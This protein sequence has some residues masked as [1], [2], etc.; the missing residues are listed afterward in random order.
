M[1]GDDGGDGTFDD[2][3]GSDFFEDDAGP[4]FSDDDAGSAP[5]DDD[6]GRK[7]RVGNDGFENVMISN[8]S[9]E[10]NSFFAANSTPGGTV[11][12]GDG[13]GYGVPCSTGTMVVVSLGEFE[14]GGGG[15]RIFRLE[16]GGGG[17]GKFEAGG[18]GG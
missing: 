3:S 18:G 2:D 5:F 4:G 9:F 17:F 8:G 7:P 13:V 15:G 12:H 6:A 16:G 10:D 1:S 14:A 11:S